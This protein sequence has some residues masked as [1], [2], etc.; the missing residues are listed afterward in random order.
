MVQLRLLQ[1]ERLS[2]EQK[3]AK[4]EVELDKQLKNASRKDPSR[5]W[6]GK[7][8]SHSTLTSSN[9]VPCTSKDV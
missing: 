1:E 7:G 6:K 3:M 8:V 5:A 4:D 2:L 9:D